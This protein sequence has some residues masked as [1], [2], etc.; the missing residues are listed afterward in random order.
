LLELVETL[1][2]SVGKSGS[3][4]FGTTVQ[5]PNK[6]IVSICG[7]LEPE[8]TGDGSVTLPSLAQ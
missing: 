5:Y 4:C 3:F 8:R 7:P 6:S 1:R 2:L